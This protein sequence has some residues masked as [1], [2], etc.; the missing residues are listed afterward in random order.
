[1]G[2]RITVVGMGPGNPDHLTM[3]AWNVLNDAERIYVRTEQHPVVPWLRERGKA[4]VSF[5]DLYEGTEDFDDLYQSITEKLTRLS[6]DGSL[7]FAVPGN[8]VQG[9][10]VVR[11]LV[12]TLEPGA[13]RLVFGAGSADLALQQI[14]ENAEPG[15]VR[16][17][18]SYLA[19]RHLDPALGWLIEQVDSSMTA[20]EVKLALIESFPEEHPI[21]RIRAA[22]ISGEESIETIPLYELDH[23]ASYDHRTTLYVPPVPVE[24]RKYRFQDL[25]DIMARLRGPEGCPWDLKQNHQSILPYLIEETYEVLD[26]IESD[27]LG[28]MEE[29]LGD[30]LLQIVFHAQIASENGYFEI[31]DVIAGI[32]DKMVTRHPHVFADGKADTPEEV[33]VNWE[34]I[35]KTEKQEKRQFESMVRIPRQMPALMR[36]YKI[37]EKAAEVGFDWDSVHGALLKVREEFDELLV[38]MENEDVDLMEAE[39]GDLL[40]AVVNVARF[41]KIRPEDALRRTSDKFLRRFEFVENKVI[42]KGKKMNECKLEELDG[43]WDEAKTLEK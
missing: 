6:A 11:R 27:D 29:E 32:C 28:L 22:G 8:P 34:A 26:A 41:L 30:L 12:D 20:S 21:M 36:S 18:A 33:L 15:L 24:L 43:Y 3:E 31:R 39:M 10:Q 4:I 14:Q 25:V 40:F 2:V 9:E 1:M 19:E 5:D 42:E 13:V 37:Q 16:I 38:E 23:D 35:K 17:A 7:V